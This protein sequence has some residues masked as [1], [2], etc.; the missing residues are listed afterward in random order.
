MGARGSSSGLPGQPCPEAIP[1]QGRARTSR[2]SAICDPPD[3]TGG[4]L[5]LRA[6]ELSAEFFR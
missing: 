3:V 6:L 2:G 5:T 1:G 4:S